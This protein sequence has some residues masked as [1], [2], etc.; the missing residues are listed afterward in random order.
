MSEIVDTYRTTRGETWDMIVFREMGSEH[1]MQDLVDA[2]PKYHGI[3]IFNGTEILNIP[4]VSEQGA[5]YQ[6]PWRR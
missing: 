6:A 3:S 4:D 1:Y 5:E 2:N